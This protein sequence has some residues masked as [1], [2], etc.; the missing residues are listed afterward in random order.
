MTWWIAFLPLSVVSV[1][2]SKDLSMVLYHDFQVI[3]LVRSVASVLMFCVSAFFTLSGVFW[4]APNQIILH[5]SQGMIGAD[6]TA[7]V[8]NSLI[9]PAAHQRTLDVCIEAKRM[10]HINQIPNSCT[11]IQLK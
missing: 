6:I 8:A 2:S 5:P 7:L 10:V 1:I 9:F 11:N 3:L 4:R